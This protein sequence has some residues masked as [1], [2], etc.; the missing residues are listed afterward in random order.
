[1]TEIMKKLCLAL[2]IACLPFGCASQKTSEAPNSEDMPQTSETD[3]TD[4]TSALSEV[5]SIQLPGVEGRIDHMAV[6]SQEG[7]LFV[8]ALGNDTLEVV[9]LKAGEPTD[10]IKG[11]KEPQGV[12]YVP[13]TDKL[14]VSN[15]EGASLSIYDGR[16]LDLI[17]EIEL[18]EDPDNVRYDPATG[19]A[20]VGYGSGEKS[21]LGVVDVEKGIKVTDIKLSG[22]PE[23]FQLEGEG[24]RIFVNVPTSGQVEVVDTEKAAV[25]EEWTIGGSAKNFPM[26]LDETDN[27]L[28]V[29]T[30]SPAKL[31]VLDTGTGKTLTTLDSSGDADDI[32]YDAKDKHIYVSGGEGTISDF[33]Q[34][35]PDNYSLI[36]KVDTAEGARTSLFVE[37]SALLYLAVP[38]QGS[39]RAEI[40]VFQTT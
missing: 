25:V 26:A 7:R 10:E 24:T 2:L 4:G 8:A 9:D 17:K 36:S 27:R 16:S 34:A 21:A 29:G 14:L 37:E 32:F 39:Q 33:K 1:M 23:S 12:V 22:H 3:Q 30:R 15:G 5:Q 19:Y 40:R 6:D 13:E 20:Y 28:F 11:L 31:L 35:D 38:H 18:D